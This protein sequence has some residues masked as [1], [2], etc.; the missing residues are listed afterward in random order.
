MNT[1]LWRPN[2]GKISNTN[3]YL[4]S[5]FVKDNF[6]FDAKNDFNKLWKWSVKNPKIFWKS[7]WDFTKVKGVLG[8]TLYEESNIFFKNKFVLYN[9]SFLSFQR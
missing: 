8:D 6:Q 9:F 1:Y 5:Q 4:Y 3:L 2:K 7:I